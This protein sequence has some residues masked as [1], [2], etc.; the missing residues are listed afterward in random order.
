MPIRLD[1]N[2]EDFTSRFAAFLA[3]KRE[4]AADVEEAAR[5]IIADVAARGDEALI[6]YTRKFDRIDVNAA[7]LR[8]TSEEIDA[9]FDACDRAAREALT[10]ACN[11]IEAYHRRQVP[12]DERYTDS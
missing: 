3:A 2:A 4:A 10:L 6:A 11:R 1:H 8:V 5:V 9:A 12:G 7:G